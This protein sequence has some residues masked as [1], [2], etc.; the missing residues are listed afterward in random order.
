MGGRLIREVKRRRR[1]TRLNAEE[2]RPGRGLEGVFSVEV[3]GN[4]SGCWEMIGE[5]RDVRARKR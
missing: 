3:V 2:V 5:E 4:G 1:M